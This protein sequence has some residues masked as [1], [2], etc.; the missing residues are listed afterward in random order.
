MRR[1]NSWRAMETH[2]G[3]PESREKKADS[4]GS[5]D[6]CEGWTSREQPSW[7][8]LENIGRW[9]T[10]MEGVKTGLT[11]DRTDSLYSTT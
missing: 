6:G 1:V 10:P 7:G 2:T 5:N 8:N 3:N 4:A 11:E 9:Q